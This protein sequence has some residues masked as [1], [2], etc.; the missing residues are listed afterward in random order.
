MA[1]FQTPT[2]ASQLSMNGAIQ[3]GAET[4]ITTDDADLF[5]SNLISP[6]VKASLQELGYTVRPLRKSDYSKGSYIR[7][8]IDAYAD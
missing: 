5:S 6:T 3:K 7:N 4:Q 1:E 8:H 2:E